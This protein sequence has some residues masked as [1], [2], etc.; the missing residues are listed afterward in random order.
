MGF[1][2]LV[3]APIAPDVPVESGNTQPAMNGVVM[4]R[5]G[6]ATLKRV[7]A[8][9]GTLLLRGRIPATSPQDQRREVTGAPSAEPRR[10]RFQALIERTRTEPVVERLRIKLGFPREVFERAVSPLIEGYAEF[11]QLLPAPGSAS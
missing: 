1:R 6:K 2:G 5:G 7:L 3:E 8:R 4:K 11:V 9:A 10:V